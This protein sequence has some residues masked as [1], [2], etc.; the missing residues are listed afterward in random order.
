M[1]QLKK[2]MTMN[3]HQRKNLMH[4]MKENKRTKELV[5]VEVVVNGN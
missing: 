1:I 4:Q 3:N 2:I 5:E